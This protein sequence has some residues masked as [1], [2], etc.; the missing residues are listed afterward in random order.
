MASPNKFVGTGV[1]KEEREKG[2]WIREK[3]ENE[4]KMENEGKEMKS[5]AVQF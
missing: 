3:K 2:K 5:S 1:R 4:G